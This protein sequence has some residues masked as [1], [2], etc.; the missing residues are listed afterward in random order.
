MADIPREYEASPPPIDT[1]GDN[2]SKTNLS[3]I[4]IEKAEDLEHVE[5]KPIPAA[6]PKHVLAKKLKSRHMQ[7]IAIGQWHGP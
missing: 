7:M 6:P 4:D 1:N 2:P 3:S 5:A